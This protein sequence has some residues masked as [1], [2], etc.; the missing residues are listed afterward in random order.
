ME[1]VKYWE[2]VQKVRRS[3]SAVVSIKYQICFKVFRRV[4][5]EH[6]SQS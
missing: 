3:Q 6:V 5:I 2:I 1:V 4:A